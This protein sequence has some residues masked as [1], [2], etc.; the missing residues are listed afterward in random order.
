MAE[1]S[2]VGKNVPRV[3][4]FE[5]VTGSAIYADD[6][7]FGAGL[8]YGR[9]VRSPYAHALIK[10]IDV[11]KAL[12]VPGVKAVVTG[13]DFPGRIG[14]YLVDRPI[15][16][17]D[18]VRYVG[19]PVAGVVAVSEEIAE[20]AARLVEVEYEE[21]P[22]V[23][24]PLEAIK[25][26][27]PLLHPDL[28]SYKVAP[29]IHPVPGTNISEHFKLRRGDVE[30]AWS[31][32]AAIVEEEFR[33]PQIQHVPIETHV[34]VAIWEPSGEVTLWTSSQSPFAQRDLIAQSLGIPHGNL[35]V[36][37][38][39]VGGGFGGKAGVSIEVYAV[40][41]ARAV[42]GHPVKL[43][44][45]REEEFVGTT[46]RQSLVAH[47]KVGCDADGNLLAMEVSYYFG[48]GAYNDY[49]VNI[50][51]AAGYS[52]TGPYYIPNVKGDSYCVYTNQPIGSAMRGFG[53]PE[54]HWGLEQ[55]MDQL[56]EKIGMDPVEFRR[57]NC[58][59]TGQIIAT[60]MTMPNVDLVACIDKVAKAVNWGK[61]EPPSAPHKKRGKGLAI[62][63]KA[64]AMPPNPGSSAIVRFNEDATVNVEIGAQE[65]GQGAFTVA[66]QIAAEALGVPY[67]WVRVSAPIDTKYSPYEWQTVASRITWSMGNAVKAAA[68]DA[69][70]QILE[71]VAEH[72]DEDP[73]DLDIKDGKVIS[74]KSERELSLK[75]LVVYGLP[76]EDFE[77]WK[78]G[79][80]VGRGKFMPTYVTSLDPETGQGT[81]AVVHYTVGA[82]AVDL[83][84]DTE[85]GQVEIIKIASAYDVGKAINPDLV[86]TQIEGGAVHG[87]SSTFEALKFDEKGRPLNPSFVD[88]RIATAA[89]IPKEIH[90]DIVETPLEDGPWGARG[91][92]EHVMVQTAPAIANA[93]Y[94]AIGVRFNELPLSAEK[95]FM[96]MREKEE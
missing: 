84:V 17:A 62:M 21:L 36:I 13:K 96:A 95:I 74:Y 37:S 59:K 86:L 90:G 44:M 78:G 35:R 71:L 76:N 66:A 91:I 64:P 65:L 4:V 23:F 61:K 40:A 51:R 24:D 48:G 43:R 50:A 60:G 14:L 31:Q 49:G 25:P 70:R 85:T 39:Y 38:P 10:K 42:M 73:E 68:E 79:P 6:R 32:C 20:E 88:Y 52:C 67:D 45:T 81:R 22:A 30:S 33:L 83:E 3:D 41:M 15:F 80:I 16:A 2:S 89:D 69:K 11:S 54:I 8:Y 53:M 58:V 94:N 63:W 72:W 12:E 57:R 27:A 9:L 29:F 82:Q 19:D 75:G 26:D 77:G 87:M 92:G 56:A 7:Q 1:F 28:G 5:K 34:A 18:R 93:I 55:A 47:V 46:V